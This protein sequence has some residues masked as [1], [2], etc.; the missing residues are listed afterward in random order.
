[1]SHAP[2][3][4][5]PSAAAGTTTPRVLAVLVSHDGAE[6]L[7]A[8]L[9]TLSAQGYPALEVLA[10]DNASTDGTDAIL[11]KR[12]GSDR[13]ITMDRDVG[14]GRGVAAALRS[15]LAADIDYVLLV[16]DDMALMPDAVQW[17]V[18]AM[19]ADPSLSVVGPKLREWDEEPLLQQVGMSADAFLR[20]ES[21]LDPGEIDQG[22]HDGRGDVLYVSTAGMLLRRDVFAS[23]GGFDA[24]FPAFRDDMD[25]CWRVWLAGRRVSIVPQAVGYHLA[26]A[27][28]GVR[29]GTDLTDARY[30][31]ERH[32]LASMLKNYSARRLAWI[33]PLGIV[34]SLLR[35][36][37][38]LLA[39]R[40]GPA[41]ALVRAYA[42]NLAQ[43]PATLRRR[44]VVQRT[45]RQS[46]ARLSALFTPG[47][48]RLRQYSES[49][50]ESLSGGSTRALVDAD[51][52]GRMGIDPLAEQPIQRFLRDRPLVLLGVPLLLAFLV[53]LGGYLGSGPLIGGEVAAWPDDPREFLVSYLSAWS[54]EP[55][56]SASFP[57]P[58]QP[59]LGLASLL[60]G[61]SA[62]LAQRAL[63]FGLLPLAFITTLRAGRLV[64]PKA[65]PR[66]IGA[67]AYVVSPVVLG[68]L[69]EGR[70]GI[71]VLA[72]LLPAIVSL[73]ITTADRR[74][75]PGVA[76]RSTALLGL[77]LVLTIGAAPVEALLGLAIVL[78]A[79]VLVLLRGRFRPVLRLSVGTGAALLIL[80]P[81][82]ADL[83]RDGGPA[84][85][86]LATAGGPPA[87]VDLPLWR[88]MVGQPLTVAGADGL[89]GTALIAL[90]AAVLLGALVVGMRARPLVTSALV[91]LV[92]ASGAAGWAAAFYRVPLIHPPALLLPGALGVAVLAII[93]AR[94][95]T[96]TLVAADFGVS[97]VGTAVAGIVLAVGLLAG[98]GLLAGGPWQALQQGPE[99]VPAFIGADRSSVGPY[100]VLLLDR[101]ED[102]T[103]RWEVTDDRGPRMTSFGTL[104][105]RDLTQAIG[106]SVTQSVSGV[107]TSA[108]A[109]LGVLN[110]RY[111]VLLQPDAELQTA[112]SRQVGLEPLTSSAAVTYRVRTWL[113]R[114]SIVPEP[115]AS[116]LQATGDPGPTDGVVAIPSSTIRPGDVRGT[117][118]PTTGILVLSE[119]GSPAWRAAGESGVL[120]PVELDLV[121]GYA[122]DGD[123]EFRVV[124]GDDL[125][126]RL[127]V[128]M[129]LLVALIIIS[130]AVRPPGRGAP[131]RRVASL[132][133]DLVGLADTT[134]AI[135]RIDPDAP[136]P[137]VRR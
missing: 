56:A 22:Q 126:R 15:D 118:A 37:A 2:P 33:V 54:G 24:R 84:G 61:G 8:A 109:R 132:P 5:L 137:G 52:I 83:V 125:R 57:S 63:V 51:D 97:Q 10:V 123:T 25:L 59:V 107:G 7:T 93:V 18:G 86:T 89:L 50:L 75:A 116:R 104:R 38:M 3:S 71:A 90:P 133:T 121:N 76:W 105:D 16:H 130:L 48:P 43:L 124:Y 91:L 36:V 112:L 32:A 4:P 39:R 85:G 111:V 26:A 79:T 62:W 11:R 77:S 81:W 106:D 102:G 99:L 117:A 29:R 120:P 21:L 1:M 134:T 113:P 65:W 45:R 69:G 96:Q 114:I 42:W 103:V 88:A 87:I 27:A 78:I 31:T 41:L 9:R 64:T 60:L 28:N 119:A 58:V 95:S 82:L 46:D 100:R 35:I 110:I 135:P 115:A 72:A 67:T 127:V 12:L 108:S 74:T 73:T 128:A 66:V 94:W 13:V 6:W 20:A 17:M 136:P 23:L 122:I 19:E 30:L 131:A 44:R 53:S 101:A 98:I 70:Y 40:V 80:A 92:V 49:L 14:F 34:L 68:T 47:L 129:Q 55:L